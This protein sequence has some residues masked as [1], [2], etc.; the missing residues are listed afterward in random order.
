M[1]R[2]MRGSRFTRRGRRKATKNSASIKAIRTAPTRPT[3]ILTARTLRQ[4]PPLALALR[5][6]LR[7]P[8]PQRSHLRALPVDDGAGAREVRRLR[9]RAGRARPLSGGDP[10]QGIGLLF[11]RLWQGKVVEGRRGL[12]ARAGHEEDGIEAGR[13]EGRVVGRRLGSGV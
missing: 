13:E 5:A 3:R 10:L 2:A 4:E 6:D 1:P 8:L 11:D 12:F 9:R 7:V